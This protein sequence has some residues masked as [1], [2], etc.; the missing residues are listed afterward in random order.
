MSDIIKNRKVVM[1][2]DNNLFTG[3]MLVNQTRCYTSIKRFCYYNHL[4][5]KSYNKILL[6]LRAGKGKCIWNNLY[7]YKLE[8]I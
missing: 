1:V 6:S 3:D 2:T 4:T 5:D 8:L 7:I